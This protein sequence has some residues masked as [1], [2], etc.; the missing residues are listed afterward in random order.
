ME[1]RRADLL[2][3]YKE[4][5]RRYKNNEGGTSR[6]DLNR[7]FEGEFNKLVIDSRSPSVACHS[8]LDTSEAA[9]P[10]SSPANG[11]T[12]LHSSASS[13][14]TNLSVSAALTAPHSPRARLPPTGAHGSHFF[15]HPS[16]TP[17]P[18]LHHSRSNSQ[19][20]S[21]SPVPP[22]AHANSQK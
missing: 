21:S 2:K 13:S 15:L 9:A 4:R 12:K 18:H 10:T 20:S 11:R 8:S 7:W 22:L 19:S 5:R 14:S 16:H 6:D 3:S 1:S 17:H